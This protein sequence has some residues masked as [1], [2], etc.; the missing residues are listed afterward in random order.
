MK[1]LYQIPEIGS[2]VNMD[3]IKMAVYGSQLHLNPFGIVPAGPAT[4]FSAPHDRRRFY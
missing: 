4:D 1:D 3:H 2:T